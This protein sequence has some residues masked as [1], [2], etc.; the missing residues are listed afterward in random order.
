MSYFKIILTDSPG[1]LAPGLKV[2]SQKNRQVLSRVDLA[3][4]MPFSLSDSFS[5]AKGH[6]CRLMRSKLL[7]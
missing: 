2:L 3:I 5:T 1:N 4:Q 6:F 7:K